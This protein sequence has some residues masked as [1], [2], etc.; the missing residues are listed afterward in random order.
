LIN[1]KTGQIDYL[2]EAQVSCC[3]LSPHLQYIAFGDENGAIKIL[4][5]VNNRIF[6]SRI[7]HKKTVRHIQ[8]TADE[9]TL[10]SSSDDSAIQ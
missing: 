2:T 8:F 5:P 10:I 7:W 3:C 6:Q 9:K 4:E 1:G